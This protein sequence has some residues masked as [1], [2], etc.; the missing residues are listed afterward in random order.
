M[1]LILHRGISTSEIDAEETVRFIKDRGFSGKEG[2]W[3]F[4]IPNIAVVREK[5]ETIFL[6]EHPTKDD[7]FGD[8]PFGGICA[9]GDKIGACYYALKHNRSQEK[10]IAILITFEA[11]IDDV[12]IDPRDFLCS[13][14]QFW[15]RETTSLKDK[16]ASILKDVYG[17]GVLRYF[18]RC[19]STSN[20][21]T[22]ITMCNLASFDTRVIEDHYLNKKIIGGRYGVMF[23]SAF[24]VKTPVVVSA[25]KHCEIISGEHKELD[26]YVDV[27]KFDKL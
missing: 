23:C 7:I 1:K 14:F 9:C 18:E 10:P 3:N 4:N 21:Q 5:L 2:I 22:R 8:T 15:D 19:T 6:A 25:I 11:S 16:Q 27:Y 17:N 26:L 12:Y 24:F 20:Q 13:A